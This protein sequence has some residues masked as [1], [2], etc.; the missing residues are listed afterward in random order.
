M[1]KR[2]IK[3]KI[4]PNTPILMGTRLGEE[5]SRI[6]F[7][8]R[9]FGYFNLSAK[10]LLCLKHPDSKLFA[11]IVADCK[12]LLYVGDAESRH[13]IWTLEQIQQ[14]LDAYPTQLSLF[15][16]KFVYNRW[17][18]NKERPVDIDENLG[19]YWDIDNTS[20]RIK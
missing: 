13:W 1:P 10:I 14:Y 8:F 15:E 12:K 6:A 3:I 7:A 19:I 11:E 2:I 16:K 20:C 4:L 5:L 17:D 9:S 18:T